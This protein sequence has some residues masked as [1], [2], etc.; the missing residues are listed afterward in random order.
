[1]GFEVSLI[2]M[3]DVG[4]DGYAAAVGHG[5]SGVHGEVEYGLMYLAR[6]ADGDGMVG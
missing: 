2:Y 4:F 3:N 5:V 6:F 1:M